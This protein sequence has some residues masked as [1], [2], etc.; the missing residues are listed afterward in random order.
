[1][2]IVKRGIHA[3]NRRDVH[4]FAELT[5]ADIEVVPAM[6]GVVEGGNY[7]GRE[8][9]ETWYRESRDTWEQ[10]PLIGDDFRD[11]GL[12]ALRARRDR[13][14]SA[15]QRRALLCECRS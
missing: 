14:W 1:M 3:Y 12:A 6:L 5:T 9:I 11:L 7:R 4:A 15:W 8:G 13:T 2:E 10:Q